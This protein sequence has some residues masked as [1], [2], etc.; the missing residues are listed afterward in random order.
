VTYN[1][2]LNRLSIKL[3]SSDFLPFVS[4]LVDSTRR[5]H[6]TYEVHTNGRNIAFRVG[7]IGETKKQARLSDT[8][9][10]DQEQ[11]EEV[12]VSRL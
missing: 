6:V 4:C 7:I 2:K 5:R 12:V 8:R 3:D 9:V 11:L 10:T 1:L